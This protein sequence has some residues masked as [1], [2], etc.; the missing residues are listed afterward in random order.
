MISSIK[1]DPIFSALTALVVGLVSVVIACNWP[2]ESRADSPQK[3]TFAGLSFVSDICKQQVDKKTIDTLLVNALKGG[4]HFKVVSDA[5]SD[6][7]ELVKNGE[8]N[9][10]P[11][12]NKNEPVRL[13]V[14]RKNCLHKDAVMYEWQFAFL[15]T[16]R[17]EVEFHQ[18]YLYHDMD[19]VISGRVPFR[20]EQMSG[21][22]NKVS[23]V[24]AALTLG[25]ASALDVQQLMEQ[26]GARQKLRVANREVI[27]SYKVDA[28]NDL[29]SRIM[30]WDF[31]LEITF[32]FN[33]G[34]VVESVTVLNR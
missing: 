34:G 6:K 12:Y 18:A 21:D 15:V 5:F 32:L 30:V 4:I 8:R 19:S 1:K 7:F 23:K 28:L 31:S 26:G 29:I 17:D 33:S 27:Y 20:F 2:L 3:E 11:V 24:L 14:F 10:D 16:D 9:I 22:K 13:Y 25:R